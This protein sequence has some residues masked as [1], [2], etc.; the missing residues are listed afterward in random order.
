MIFGAFERMVAMRYLRARRQEGSLSI[1]AIFSVVGIT[2]GVGTLIVVM[3]VMNGFRE[4]LLSRI[5]G[6]NGHLTV[7]ANQGSITDFEAMGER[8]LAI[9]GISQAI[10]QI[11]AQIVV[12]QGANALGAAVRGLRTTDLKARALVAENVTTGSLN[13]FE[14]G[15]GVLVGGRLAQRLRLGVGDMITLVS[16]RGEQTAIGT[17]P[18]I[19]SYPIAGLFEVGMYEYDS[20]FIYMPLADAQK[21]FRY[22]DRVNAVELFVA[23]P[24]RVPEL[25][26]DVVESLGPGYRTVDW[27]QANSSFFSVVQVERNVMA[28]I[29]TLIIVVATFNIISGQIVLVRDKGHDIAIL[30]TMGATRGMILRI[31]LMTG[32]IIGAVGTLFGCLIGVV[33]AQ[34][35]EVFRKLMQSLTGAELFPAEFYFLSQLPSKIVPEEVV[36]VAVVVAG[37]GTTVAVKVTS[38]TLRV[39]KPPLVATSVN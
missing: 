1:I 12:S 23:D 3:A 10:P 27:Q 21:F 14:A 36:V 11:Q 33:F 26:D 29:L 16:P 15:R 28:L 7:Y 18:R 9:Q 25:R 22:P 8:L 37:S 5:L 20:S 34:N 38:D 24:D 39:S 30:R 35:I 31:F 17:L 32:T 2:L 4:D 13:G 6:I 19:K